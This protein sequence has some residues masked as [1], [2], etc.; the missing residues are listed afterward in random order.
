MSVAAGSIELNQCNNTALRKASRRLSQAY[1]EILSPSGLRSTQLSVLAEID[2]GAGLPPMMGA[3]ADAL[4]MD[5]STLGKNLRPLE[6]DGF[7][8]F[9]VDPTDRRTKRVVLTPAGRTKIS[10]AQVMWQAAQQQFENKY[11]VEEATA[12]RK[13]LLRVAADTQPPTAP[14]A[15]RQQEIRRLL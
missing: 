6:R 8:T 2:R 9:A 11:G 13:A 1:D 14:N 7:I 10:E 15:A 12:L 4:V 3:L 5:R